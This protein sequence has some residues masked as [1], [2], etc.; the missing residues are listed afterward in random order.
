MPKVIL[1][2]VTE[3]ENYDSCRNDNYIVLPKDTD[4]HEVIKKC[5]ESNSCGFARS[6]IN[7]GKGKY[8]I[9]SPKKNRDHIIE[10]LNAYDGVN[11]YVLD[12]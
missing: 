8:Y 11:F 12:Y 5:M 9:R 7:D 6:S 2:K 1:P 4:I 10:R 3:Y